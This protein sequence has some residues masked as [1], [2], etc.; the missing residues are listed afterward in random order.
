MVLTPEFWIDFSKKNT[1]EQF[2]EQIIRNDAYIKINKLEKSYHSVSCCLYQ[3]QDFTT[4]YKEIIN[5]IKNRI[6]DLNIKDS[7][8]VEWIIRPQDE[9]KNLPELLTELGYKKK[10]TFYK[11]GIDLDSYE[12]DSEIKDSTFDIEKVENERI[13][14]EPILS[15][16]L[17]NFPT[18]FLDTEDAKR[19]MEN[20]FLIHEK[21]GNK[22]EH[23]LVYTKLEHKPIALASLLIRNDIPN[24]AYLEGALT[25]KEYR[26]KGIYSELLRK[27]IQR[28]KELGLRYIVVDSDQS[29]SAPILKKFGFKVFD[30]VDFYR[31]KF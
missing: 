13:L 24:M 8:G 9:P 10:V 2:Q 21:K 22:S 6:Q 25:E 23:F 14:E 12:I 31:L 29:T 27:R 4:F 15:L 1:D 5:Q 18:Q 7:L 16:L 26:N 20:M 19:K 28:C 17:K 3:G 11:M 30:T